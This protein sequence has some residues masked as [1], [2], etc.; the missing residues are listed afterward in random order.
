MDIITEI[1]V[2]DLEV[3]ASKAVVTISD[4]ADFYPD[5][6]FDCGQAFRWNRDGNGYIGKLVR[7]QKYDPWKI[8]AWINTIG[9]GGII[10]TWTEITVRSRG[11]YPPIRL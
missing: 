4:T 1:G 11:N 2:Q 5:H 7:N 6:I 3:T 8:A 10:L 9:S